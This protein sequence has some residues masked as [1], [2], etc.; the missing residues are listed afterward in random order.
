[1][2]GRNMVKLKT[3]INN[4]NTVNRIFDETGTIIKKSGA[5]IGP[6]DKLE[7]I[8]LLWMDFYIGFSKNAGYSLTQ[9]DKYV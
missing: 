2:L 8:S 6:F 5:Y 7:N 3:F 1:M 4:N 9:L